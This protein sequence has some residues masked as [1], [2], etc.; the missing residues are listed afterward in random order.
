LLKIVSLI[1]LFI[2]KVNEVIQQN[3]EVE[4]VHELPVLQVDAVLSSIEENVT[5]KEENGTLKNELS[6]LTHEEK[7]LIAVNNLDLNELEIDNKENN[8]TNMA[9]SDSQVNQEVTN[10]ICTEVKHSTPILI[11]KHKTVAPREREIID[12][13]QDHSTY[14]QR[15]IEKMQGEGFGSDQFPNSKGYCRLERE[16]LELEKEKKLLAEGGIMENNAA[17]LSS[18]YQSKRKFNETGSKF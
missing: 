4:E 16:K 15:K 8:T 12:Y 11:S 1:I 18:K 3:E 10:P 2:Y 13:D 14:L 7:Q 17:S 6:E 9:I 5:M